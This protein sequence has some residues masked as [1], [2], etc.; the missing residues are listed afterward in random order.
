MIHMYSSF[1]DVA[2]YADVAKRHGIALI[3]DASQAHG[4]SWHGRRIGSFG[5]ISIFS[6][7]Q[8]KL[9]TS[10]EGGLC[11]TDAP[12]L[13]TRLQQL[14]ADG[15]QYR[16]DPFPPIAHDS[17]IRSS[18]DG[19]GHRLSTIAPDGYE[20]KAAGDVAGQNL[21]LTEFQAALLLDGLDRLD[22]EN[23]HRRTCVDALA[24]CLASV[25]GIQLIK[26]ST[27]VDGPTYYR[28]TLRIDRS[29]FAGLSAREVVPALAAELGTDIRC[30]DAPL[31]AHP[32]YA[33]TRAPLSARNPKFRK[34]LEPSQFA[35][36]NAERAYAEVVTFPHQ[37]LLAAPEDMQDVAD[38]LEKVRCCAQLLKARASEIEVPEE[39]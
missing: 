16:V 25:D 23:V 13:Y 14:R 34:A 22:Q 38:A 21:C 7:Q 9:L 39:V 19:L 8:S 37:M 5:E 2:A 31:N 29:A 30:V 18:H 35:L 10:G 4:A 24:A 26:P 33:P 12:I 20:L 11:V 27:D 1:C 32:L 6:T 15:R 3:E 36:P 28:L 17:E